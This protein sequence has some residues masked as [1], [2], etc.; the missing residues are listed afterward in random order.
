MMAHEV[1]KAQVLNVLTFNR[2][3]VLTKLDFQHTY[4]TDHK[5]EICCVYTMC[6][7]FCCE[8]LQH[9]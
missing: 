4:L 6:G 9:Q 7:R 1:H 5:T 3:C 2:K 8:P